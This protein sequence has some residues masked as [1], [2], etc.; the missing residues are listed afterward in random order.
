MT[1]GQYEFLIELGLQNRLNLPAYEQVPVWIGEKFPYPS[2]KS[3]KAKVNRL[4]SILQNYEAS[5][6]HPNIRTKNANYIS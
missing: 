6:E 3:I 4:N 1:I 2:P 5:A